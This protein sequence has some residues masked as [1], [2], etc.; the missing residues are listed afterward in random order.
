[1]KTMSTDTQ[2]RQADGKWAEKV[3]LPGDVSLSDADP[4][5]TAS[6]AQN[7]DVASALNLRHSYVSTQV[8]RTPAGPAS[9]VISSQATDEQGRVWVVTTRYD[10]LHTNLGTSAYVK[11]DGD[12]HSYV[13]N[14]AGPGEDVQIEDMVNEAKR[15]I[16]VQ[17]L[18]SR[19]GEEQGRF[20]SDAFGDEGGVVEASVVSLRGG[21]RVAVTDSRDSD[22]DLSCILHFDGSGHVDSIDVDVFGLTNA[23]VKDPETID[24]LMSRMDEEVSWNLDTGSGSLRGRLS[25]AVQAAGDPRG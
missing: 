2:P 24:R 22:V 9:V 20:D 23:G 25:E 19:I 17:R 13:N 14:I 6:L 11:W 8:H 12:A 10:D 5:E 3:H 16:P 1:M 15:M 18:L 4:W 21:A 7:E